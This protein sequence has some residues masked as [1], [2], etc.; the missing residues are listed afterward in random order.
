ML[1]AK[2]EMLGIGALETRFACFRILLRQY[3]SIICVHR[4][5]LLLAWMISFISVMMKCFTNHLE[6]IQSALN[7]S[8][9]RTKGVR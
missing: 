4:N 8:V 1:N 3:S 7:A 2:E 9:G 6:C 5:G